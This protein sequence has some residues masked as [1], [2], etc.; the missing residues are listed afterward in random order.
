MK[1]NKII[2]SLILTLTISNT[3]G[4][5]EPHTT[6]SQNTLYKCDSLRT[7]LK[8][9]GDFMPKLENKLVQQLGTIQL[10]APNKKRSLSLHNN[11]YLSAYSTPL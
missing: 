9:I 8:F 1:I 7:A 2:F 3:Y 4:M 10:I 5:V 6:S 11:K